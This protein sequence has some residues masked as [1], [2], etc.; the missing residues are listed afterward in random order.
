MVALVSR[1]G[2]VVVKT[3]VNW[4]VERPGTGR[5]RRDDFEGWRWVWRVRRGGLRRRIALVWDAWRRGDRRERNMADWVDTGCCRRWN[6][7][8]GD[9]DD[10]KSDRNVG[11]TSLRIRL[12]L[13]LKEV[14]K[15]DTF[16]FLDVITIIIAKCSCVLRHVSRLVAIM[17]NRSSQFSTLPYHLS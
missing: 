10:G 1:F 8:G 9:G 12:D 17:N 3:R 13:H 7:G 5:E 15:F 4:I 14:L 11:R 16:A 6:D 2:V